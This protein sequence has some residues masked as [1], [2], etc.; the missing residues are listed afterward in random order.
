MTAP[1]RYRCP[2]TTLASTQRERR[3]LLS[4]SVGEAAAP[5]TASTTTETT[6]TPATSN[7]RRVCVLVSVTAHAGSVPSMLVY[8]IQYRFR[9]MCKTITGAQWASLSPAKRGAHITTLPVHPGA[10]YRPPISISTCI[11]LAVSSRSPS[12]DGRV[13]PVNVRWCA[14]KTPWDIGLL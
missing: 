7:P 6:G 13:V 11:Y 14:R 4:L 8:Y 3:R 10:S 2:T 5:T 9:F 12:Q 1:Y